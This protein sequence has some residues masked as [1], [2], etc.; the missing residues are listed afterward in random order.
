MRGFEQAI[1]KPRYHLTQ[2][3]RPAML[4]LVTVARSRIPRGPFAHPQWAFCRCGFLLCIWER[5]NRSC[6]ITRK[7]WTNIWKILRR[8]SKI[9]STPDCGTCSCLWSL[10]ISPFCWRRPARRRCPCCTGCC[11]RSWRR[12]CSW[13]WSPTPRRCSSTAFP[14]PS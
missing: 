8:L 9:S 4:K 7:N 6:S 11:P 1:S 12:R 5:R 14:T 2:F 10:R 13:S 3:H